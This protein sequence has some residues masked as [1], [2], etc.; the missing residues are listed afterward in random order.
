[1]TGEAKVKGVKDFLESIL[2]NSSKNKFILFAHHQSVLDQLEEF[3]LNKLE[4]DHLI[5]IDG[6]TDPKHR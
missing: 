4:G 6:N 2:N 3:L 1:M 5:R